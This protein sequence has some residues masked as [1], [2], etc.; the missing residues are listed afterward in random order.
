MFLRNVCRVSSD[1]TA[2]YTGRQN[3]VRGDGLRPTIEN[4]EPRAT[5]RNEARQ[6]VH[7]DEFSGQAGRS[8]GTEALAGKA[9]IVARDDAMLHKRQRG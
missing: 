3:V 1:Y 8:V 5:S 9:H 7:S 6:S 4:K 2:L